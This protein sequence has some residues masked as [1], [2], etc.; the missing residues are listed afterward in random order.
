MVGIEYLV[1]T[2]KRVYGKTRL[3]KFSKTELYNK[4]DLGIRNPKY[5]R[6]K[7][8]PKSNDMPSVNSPKI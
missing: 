4:Y 7:I 2:L 6:R 5:Q 3:E 8:A 1:T